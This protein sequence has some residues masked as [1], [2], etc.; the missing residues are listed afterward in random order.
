[1]FVVKLIEN[2]TK[3]EH[4]KR[5]QLKCGD[6]SFIVDGEC[7]L[8]VN[9]RSVKIATSTAA[10]LLPFLTGQLNRAKHQ[11][12]H[13]QRS[14]SQDQHGSPAPHR[15]DFPSTSTNGN[16]TVSVDSRRPRPVTLYKKAS[17]PPR[18]PPDRRSSSAGSHGEE[19]EEKK[20]EEA[21]IESIKK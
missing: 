13:T 4:Q 9:G 16:V 8:K 10:N 1:M 7:S 12:F 20:K 2:A 11:I 19:S 3:S 18:P 21:A 14:Q 15:P 6:Q 17:E 5:F